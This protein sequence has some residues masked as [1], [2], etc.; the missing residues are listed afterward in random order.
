MVKQ[1]LV[2]MSHYLDV[3]QFQDRAQKENQPTRYIDQYITELSFDEKA[4]ILSASKSV[5][6]LL[7]QI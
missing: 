5:L 1:V 6:I 7:N 3:R 4:L 2:N